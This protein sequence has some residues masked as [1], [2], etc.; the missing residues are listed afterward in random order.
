MP[1]EML[2]A[3]GGPDHD[4]TQN[5]RSRNQLPSFA[6]QQTP[7]QPRR[8]GV[9]RKYGKTRS[10]PTLATS[11][12]LSIIKASAALTSNACPVAI[13][14]NAGHRAIFDKEEQLHDLLDTA[15]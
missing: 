14:G 10:T 7:L 2:Q 15:F 5:L 9:P 8:T 11:H 3:S 6:F 4:P 13:T 12:T 1:P